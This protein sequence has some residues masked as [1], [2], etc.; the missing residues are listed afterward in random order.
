[1]EQSGRNQDEDGY[2]PVWVRGHL[3]GGGAPGPSIS[4]GKTFRTRKCCI[5]GM[6]GNVSFRHKPNARPGDAP[7][8]ASPGLG[9]GVHGLLCVV[10]PS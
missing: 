7:K 10:S 8:G 4:T 1:M 3:E 2:A 5:L 9:G 6:K